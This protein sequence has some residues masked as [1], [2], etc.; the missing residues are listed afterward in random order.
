MPTPNVLSPELR[1]RWQALLDYLG[2]L[3]SLLVAYSGGVD[4]SLL[5]AAAS[6]ALGERVKAALCLG[7]FTPPWEAEAA[8]R[9]AAELGV[10]LVEV[11]AA[12]LEQDEIAANDPQR[13]YHCKRLRLGLLRDLAPALGLA[14]VAEGSQ[15]DDRQGHRPGAQAVAELGIV[16][17]LQQAGLNKADV[18][19]LAAWLGL[20]SSAAPSGACLATRIPF[21]TPLD[22]EALAR[23]ARAE[24]ALKPL[25]PG[26]LRVRDHWPLA[27]LELA[28]E[29]LAR[30]VQP[31]LR[32]DI[33]DKLTSAGYRWVT[34]DLSGYGP[35]GDRQLR[36]PKTS[37]ARNRGKGEH[38]VPDHN[39]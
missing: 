28:P 31:G 9:Q 3:D 18:R 21:G 29:D 38:E 39:A 15:T 4:S 10:E 6:Q 37:T 35:S 13:C 2:S 22:A 32:Q 16:S 36:E 23:V 27:R 14:A 8:R 5:L 26:Q 1:G 25:F 33:V 20:E 11:D 17:P 7:A 30:A 34:L 19:A 24:E 12:E